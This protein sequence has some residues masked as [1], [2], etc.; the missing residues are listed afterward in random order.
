MWVLVGLR[1][2]NFPLN[3][4]AWKVGGALASG[5]SIVLMCSP[6]AVLTTTALAALVDEAGFPPGAFN[7]VYGAPSLAEHLCPHPAVAFVTFTRPAAAGQRHLAPTAPTPERGGPQ[8][9]RK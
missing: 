7:F 1:A 2:F 9:G 4:A 6:R 5:C 8:P 3:L